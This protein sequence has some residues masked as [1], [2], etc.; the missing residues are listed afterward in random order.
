MLGERITSQSEVIRASAS[1][2]GQCCGARTKQHEDDGHE[3][4][5]ICT[6]GRRHSGVKW[7]GRR[8]SMR[9]RMARHRQRQHHRKRLQH[10]QCSG[11]AAPSSCSIEWR[12]PSL[13]TPLCRR[14]AQI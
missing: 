1:G 10:R 3:E 7:G 8:H 2:C 4:N 9:Q 5:Q 14:P 13:F 12:R 11:D 6:T